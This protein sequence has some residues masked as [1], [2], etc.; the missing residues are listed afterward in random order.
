MTKYEKIMEKVEKLERAMFQAKSE[1]F[2]DMW[3]KQSEK[4]KYK[5]SKMTIKELKE[6]E[7]E[8]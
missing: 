4:L 1:G 8:I 3:F 5:L 7:Y 6:V 2:K